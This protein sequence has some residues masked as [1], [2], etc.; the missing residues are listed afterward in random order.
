MSS[1][2]EW[3]N[4]IA[5]AGMMVLMLGLGVLL[6]VGTFHDT[7]RITLLEH[8]RRGASHY[9]KRKAP[10]PR[11]VAI[12]TVGAWLVTFAGYSLIVGSFALSYAGVLIFAVTMSVMSMPAVILL[13]LRWCRERDHGG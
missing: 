8:F 3:L 12:R 7:E 9:A 13:C 5:T 10:A 6:L 11:T 1:A 4:W 2:S